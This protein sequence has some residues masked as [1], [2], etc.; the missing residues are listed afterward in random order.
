MREKIQIVDTNTNNTHEQTIAFL[1]KE[2]DSPEEKARAISGFLNEKIDSLSVGE[3]NRSLDVFFD[4]VKQLERGQQQKFV[5]DLAKML[6]SP[7]ITGTGDQTM[8]MKILDFIP[9]AGGSKEALQAVE[10]FA[11]MVERD[12]KLYS[13]TSDKS[14]SGSRIGTALHY[15][16]EPVKIEPVKEEDEE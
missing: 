1:D 11:E 13:K 12:P 3:I 6:L 15:C 5:P 16:M 2:Y 8:I 9:D 7:K 10:K 14:Q 4:T